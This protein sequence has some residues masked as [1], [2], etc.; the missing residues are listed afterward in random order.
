[1]RG[2]GHWRR[3]WCGRG[4]ERG[5]RRVCVRPRGRVGAR[6]PVVCEHARDSVHQVSALAMASTDA[7]ACTFARDAC[8]R[9]CSRVRA[10]TCTHR[11]R[12][13]VTRA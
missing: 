10:R 6:A 13:Q 9:A 5:R 1:M 7:C 12:L 2:R 11:G 4:R 8:V 3:R